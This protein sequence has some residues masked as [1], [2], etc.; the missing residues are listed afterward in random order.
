MTVWLTVAFLF[1]L[2]PSAQGLLP[3]GRYPGADRGWNSRGYDR[4]HVHRRLYERPVRRGAQLQPDEDQSSPVGHGKHWECWIPSSRN[5]GFPP[6]GLL[7][8]LHRECC[9]SLLGWSKAQA[10]QGTRSC[11]GRCSLLK[12]SVCATEQ[13]LP[14]SDGSPGKAAPCPRSQEAAAWLS[15]A[16]TLV[17]LSRHSD[18]VSVCSPVVIFV[19]SSLFMCWD[20]FPFQLSTNVFLFCVILSLSHMLSCVSGTE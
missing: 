2:P 14:G 5:A 20:P 8:S 17:T 4:G 11:P 19:L 16:Q 13:A 9:T 12:F 18:V 1:P 7:D 3:G 10:Q 15:S 6:L